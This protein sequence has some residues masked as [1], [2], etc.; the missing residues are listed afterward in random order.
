[1]GHPALRK[2]A[3]FTYRDYLS[4]PEGERYELIDGLVFAMSPA[5]L[6]EH[7]AIVGELFFQLRSQ[8]EGQPCRP[9]IAPVDVRLTR[10][11][12]DASGADEDQIDTVVQPDLLVVCDEKKLDARGVR[13][14]P[15][16]V[17]EVLSPATAARD[18][19]EK[20]RVYERAGV[21]EYWL[22]H[23]TDRLLTVYRRQADVFSGPE[24]LAL[25]GTTTIEALPGLKI[26]WEPIVRVLGS[27]LK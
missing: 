6:L 27:V 21:R 4:W 23:P 12:Q 16:F 20:K 13:G 1:M 22:V 14:A 19:L 11:E 10:S 17:V 2:N 26:S 8:L 24:I 5:P 9:F 7:Q 18:H 3:R 25:T 15:D